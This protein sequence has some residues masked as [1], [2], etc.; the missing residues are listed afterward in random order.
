M[1]DYTTKFLGLDLKNPLI[2]SACSKTREL[3]HSKRFVELGASAIVLPSLFEEELVFNQ[4]ELQSFL[5]YSSHLSP[6]SSDFLPNFQNL[7]NAEGESYLE[8]IAAHK[9]ALHVPIIASLNGHSPSGWEK[10]AKKI[11]DAGASAL[12]L[13]IYFVPT[14]PNK[15]ALQIEAEYLEIIK[16]VRSKI[17][18]PLTIKLSPYFT[19][20][21]NMAKK[22]E[23]TGV[24]GI[25]IFNRFIEPDFDIESMDIN[26]KLQ[27]SNAEEMKLSLH[28]TAIL[29]G[30]LNLSIC[31]GRGVKNEFD[32]IKLLMAG[33]D[34]VGIASVIY[35][36]GPSKISS[37]LDGAKKWLSEHDYHSISELKGSMSYK[38]V[39]DPSAYERANYMK[40][41]KNNY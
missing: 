16:N 30:Q 37:I 23:S 39:S 7:S 6:E 36:D 14:N 28:W 10:Y 22:I 40:I 1:F 9:K 11:E 29:R 35:Q 31:A 5:T 32:F 3:E 4:N 12:E 21:S 27:F 20:F 41:L 13:N 26:P 25:T 18:I 15:D 33:A 2:I 38:N 17:K 24:E 8:L 19:N 34:A